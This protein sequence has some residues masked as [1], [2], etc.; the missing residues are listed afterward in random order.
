[1]VRGNYERRALACVDQDA[2]L[3]AQLVASR[4]EQ[5]FDASAGWLVLD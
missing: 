4:E 1:M 3:G 2:E 5:R